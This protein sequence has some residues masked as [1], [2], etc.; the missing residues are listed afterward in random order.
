MDEHSLRQG[1]GIEAQHTV[2]QLQSRVSCPSS[3]H[4]TEPGRSIYTVG[5]VLNARFN[6]CVLRFFPYIANSMIV[7][8]D[9]AVY[10]VLLLDLFLRFN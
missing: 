7:H 10:G 6:N 2:V 1:Q 5:L 8:V 3:P 9:V 4:L